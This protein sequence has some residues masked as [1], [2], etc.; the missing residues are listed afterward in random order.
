MHEIFDIS[1]VSYYT[2][3]G[4]RTS[5]RQSSACDLG[6]YRLG[7][8]SI[9]PYQDNKLHNVGYT[10]LLHAP[11]MC[12]TC[13]LQV[14]GLYNMVFIELISIAGVTEKSHSIQKYDYMFYSN[15]FPSVQINCR[16]LENF[17]FTYNF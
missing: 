8:Q 10:P 15:T 12:I 6:L 17:D 4:E 14:H 3:N 9:Q 2:D 16:Y 1:K 11:N 13:V 7:P 5:A